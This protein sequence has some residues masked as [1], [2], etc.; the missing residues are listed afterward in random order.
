MEKSIIL[1][2]RLMTI[3]KNVPVGASV[4][5][6][7]TDHGRLPVYLL[8]C[9]IAKSVIACDI[10]PLPLER[11]VRCAEYWNMRSLIDFRL[12]DGLECVSPGEVNCIV[13]AGMG[14]GTIGDI[15][16][17][18]TWVHDSGCRLV[19]QP[20][21]SADDLR[22]YL[23]ENAFEILN[24]EL[25]K[26]ESG[27]YTVITAEGGKQR[28]WQIWEEYASQALLDNREEL[29]MEYLLA[30]VK[31]LERALAGAK[32]SSKVCDISRAADFEAALSGLKE[33]IGN[34]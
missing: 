8:Q 9:K 32:A 19:L 17:R 16:K 30:L 18:A 26:E 4:A 1:S 13:I 7:G 11:A 20:M 3:A 15:L 10:S 21:S 31:R 23:Y 25:I 28:R 34:I 2:D 12:G 27:L 14:G 33:R 22:R 29:G 5:D 24:E 6:V